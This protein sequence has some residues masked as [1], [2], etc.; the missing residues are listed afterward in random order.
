MIQSIDFIVNCNNITMLWVK[1]LDNA[2][3]AYRSHAY[4]DMPHVTSLQAPRNFF[5]DKACL[6]DTPHALF[7]PLAAT[8]RVR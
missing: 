6:E 3:I 2:S 1:F 7:C 4:Q 8:C 5:Y